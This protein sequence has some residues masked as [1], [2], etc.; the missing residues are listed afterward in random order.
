MW[1][2]EDRIGRLSGASSSEWDRDLGTLYKL[3]GVGHL[4]AELSRIDRLIRERVIR[5]QA[6]GRQDD[7][8]RGLYISDDDVDAVLRSPSP[9]V[10]ASGVSGQVMPGS[11]ESDAITRRPADQ[12]SALESAT[13]RL[14]RLASAFE[15][16]AFDLDVLLLCLAPEF[17]TRYGRLYAYV[18]DDVTRKYPT[19]DLTIELLCPDPV[20][21]LHAWRRFT[22]GAPLLRHRIV[23]LH[24]NQ[25]SSGGSLRERFVKLDERVAGFL[26]GS[27]ELDQRLK[28]MVRLARC[29]PRGEIVLPQ[30]VVDR[31]RSVAGVG[32]GRSREQSLWLF[33]GA[34]DSGKRTAAKMLCHELKKELL[35]VDLSRLAGGGVPL[36]MVLDLV[37]RE[38]RLR[39]AALYFDRCEAVLTDSASSSVFASSLDA[40]L[41]GFRGLCFFGV[42]S[43]LR[44]P[45]ER[46]VTRLEFGESTA[47]ERVRLWQR[48]LGDEAAVLGDGLA[49][50]SE[51]FR[52]SGC[53]I[54]AAVAEARTLARSAGEDA[55]RITLA[56]L[57][58]AC[59]SQSTHHLESVSQR[60]TP[61]YGWEDIVLPRDQMAQLREICSYLEHR[62]KVLDEWGYGRKVVRTRGLNALFAGPSG[63]GKTMAAEIIAGDLGLEL[64]RIDL[65]MVVSKYIGETEKN[66]DKVFKEGHDSNAILFFDEADALFGK[67][68]E[69]RD[70]HDRYANIEIAY[71]L[72]KMEDYDGLVILATNLRKNLDEAFVRR[73]HFAV[74][75]PFPEEADRLRIWS[76]VFPSD[77]PLGDDLDLPFMAR[78]FRITG[79]S[80][81]NV[82]L[83]AAF[84]AADED[85]PI[86]MAHLIRGVKREYQKMG[87][88]CIEAD[89]GQYYEVV[90]ADLG[91]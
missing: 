65:S 88:L 76:R 18:Q 73:L 22:P 10:S 54:R 53:Q 1:P 25:G 43:H 5:F 70:S 89:F 36:E 33:E 77:A 31:L 41:S 66:L 83:A 27:D 71:L 2:S 52:L 74:D 19:V 72:M 26:M 61:R 44:L 20:D 49:A 91:Q 48:E 64:Y 4:R 56:S 51:R 8:F 81:R 67:R 11:V 59:R 34:A 12:W 24:E 38:A 37:F 30:T 16:T 86:E 62:H 68:S 82:A 7:Q 42:Q 58:Q 84:L 85:C 17:D 75:F 57:H 69:V 35:L 14:A 60:I 47:T 55:G 21:A 50:L 28:G 13:S 45:T 78:Q 29:D 39:E 79:G 32:G 6:E 87:K 3:D 80:I 15:L 63:T 90:R 40:H 23:S 9:W 46:S